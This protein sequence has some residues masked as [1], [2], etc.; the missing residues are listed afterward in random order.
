MVGIYVVPNVHLPLTFVG[1]MNFASWTILAQN[2][3]VRSSHRER[4]SP[5][6][7]CL[8]CTRSTL[9]YYLT[10][11]VKVD[12]FHGLSHKQVASNCLF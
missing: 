7:T 1:F 5:K 2:R 3:F 8:P 11:L 6:K 9:V 12:K 4:A 10:K